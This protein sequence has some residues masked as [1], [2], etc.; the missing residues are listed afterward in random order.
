MEK[1]QY[2]FGENDYECQM[3]NSFINTDEGKLVNVNLFIE[4][5][6][7]LAKRSRNLG[8]RIPIVMNV[9]CCRGISS[10]QT[11]DSIRKKLL[12]SFFRIG[13]SKRT[14]I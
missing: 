11:I 12:F 5:L 3:S 2:L 9:Q 13:S 14:R 10:N 6:G 4:D 7:A 1:L 8:Q